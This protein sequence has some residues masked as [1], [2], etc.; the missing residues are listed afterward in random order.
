MNFV[1]ENCSC[2]LAQ[3]KLAQCTHKWSPNLSAALRCL[4]MSHNMSFPSSIACQTVRRL[5]T[6]PVCQH[7]YSGAV[8][9]RTLAPL[10]S[11][12]LGQPCTLPCGELKSSSSL[13]KI[14][15][16]YWEKNELNISYFWWLC[17]MSNNAVP[18]YVSDQVEDNRRTYT[19]TT[20]VYANTNY[21][22]CVYHEKMSHFV[23]HF[24]QEYLQQPTM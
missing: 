2:P 17:S 3:S 6:G 21:L 9:S 5:S 8:T 11:A 10:H 14:N 13:S 16:Q 23:S 22:H 12:A 4:L 20:Q 1:F 19:S 24:R 15:T 7:P 18:T